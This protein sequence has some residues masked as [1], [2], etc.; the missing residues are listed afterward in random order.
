MTVELAA[1][2]GKGAT[3]RLQSNP[4]QIYA[5]GLT[6]DVHSNGETASIELRY[7]TVKVAKAVLRAIVKA[8][9]IED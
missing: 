5:S 3:H 4:N 2:L 7:T 9:G 6:V 1:L 8:G